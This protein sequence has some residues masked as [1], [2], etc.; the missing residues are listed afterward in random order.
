[1]RDTTSRRRAQAAPSILKSISN[2]KLE[3]F[4]RF[5]DLSLDMLCIAGLDG[6]FKMV[7]P[8]WQATLGFSVEEMVNRPF[9]E[10]IHPDDVEATNEMYATQI[11]QGKDIVQFENR[12]LC[13]DG[14]YKWLMWNAKT[15]TEEELIYA[16]ARDVTERRRVEEMLQRL[17]AIV[18]SS[19]DAIIGKTLD[20]VITSW[21]RG[22]EQLFGYSVDEAVGRPISLII[23]PDR[24]E[25]MPAILR[26]I[27]RGEGV[28]NFESRRLGKDG[29]LLDVSLTVS[30]VRDSRGRITGASTIGRDISEHKRTEEALAQKTLELER[31]N[32]ELEDFTHVVSHDLKEPLRGIEAFSGFLAEDYAGNLDERGRSYLKVLQDSAVR[33]RDLI[34]D[35]LQLSRIGR[36]QPQYRYVSMGSLLEE[37]VQGMQFS[38]KDEDVDLHVAPDLPALVCDPVRIRQVFENLISNAIKYC[39]KTPPVIEI[40]CIE[41]QGAYTFSVGDNGPGIDPKYQENIFRI[42]QRLVLREDHEGS[43]VGLTICKKIIEG[44]GGRIWVESDGQGHGSIFSFSIPKSIEPGEAKED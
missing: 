42:F 34:D 38:L 20:G 37:I 8:A 19:E 11:E 43:G 29:H 4:Q 31:S 35:L 23:P 14:S 6:Y 36:I 40:A 41:D 3:G 5:F 27:A 17:A 2:A 22:A 44:H 7:N 26:N 33:L 18:D 13:K 1:M 32:A 9:I 25:E 30:P 24:S 28:H 16:V 10:F 15:V 21:N 12:Y 39:D